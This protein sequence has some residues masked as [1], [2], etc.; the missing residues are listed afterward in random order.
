MA[1]A[2]PSSIIDFQTFIGPVKV[3]L[4]PGRGRGLIATTDIKMGTIIFA[5]KAA[6]V[7]FDTNSEKHSELLPLVL[8]QNAKGDASVLNQL[9]QMYA[10]PNYEQPASG[11]E[12]FTGQNVEEKELISS[13]RISGIC[14]F[15]TFGFKTVFGAG[16]GIWPL[17]ALTNHS[18]LANLCRL[19]IN[20]V[21]VLIANCD[22]SQGQELLS[23]YV[24]ANDNYVERTRALIPFGVECNC[25]LC[26][27]DRQ[28]LVSGMLERRIDILD[29]Y[30]TNIEQHVGTGHPEV[31]TIVLDLVD[32]L[33]NS[34]GNNILKPMMFNILSDLATIYYLKGENLLA[35]QTFERCIA[36]YGHSITIGPQLVKIPIVFSSLADATFQ[37]AVACW[38][39]GDEEA[40]RMWVKKTRYLAKGSRGFDEEM[41][42]QKYQSLV[43]GVDL[44]RIQWF[45]LG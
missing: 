27:C 20:N 24:A 28:D 30:S 10:G 32:Q 6:G 9:W 3:E 16:Q 35:T 33:E 22:I 13:E 1:A 26:D 39:M 25:Q 19:F 4:F 11:L 7:V 5:E 45:L 31:E 42:E 34:Y 37:F 41:F 15:N 2:S 23:S 18:C 40:F 17:A 36:S 8:Q 29:Y 43:P 21:I 14:D 12:S 44:K 38:Q